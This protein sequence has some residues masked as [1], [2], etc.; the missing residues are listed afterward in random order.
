MLSSS[1][2]SIQ[3]LPAARFLGISNVQC[4]LFELD[5]HGRLTGGIVKPIVWG[6][7]Q[8]RRGA[9]ILFCQ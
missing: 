3:A 4:N 1:A 2:L 5:E 8:G 6:G 9:T 7:D